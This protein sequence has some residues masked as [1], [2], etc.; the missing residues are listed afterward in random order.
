MILKDVL[1]KIETL[2]GADIVSLKHMAKYVWF[3]GPNGAPTVFAHGE[4]W[5]MAPEKTVM[6]LGMFQGDND[7]RVYTLAV[8]DSK[9][10]PTCYTLDKRSPTMVCESMSLDTFIAEMA[11]EWSVL[12]AEMSTAEKERESIV[13]FLQKM[14]G[15]A[16][17]VGLI[18]EG[19]HLEEEDEE[20]EPVL[21]GQTSSTL[22]NAPPP[23]APS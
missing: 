17:L 6:I 21:P 5:P 3:A 23:G 7:V 14:N 22:P 12:D 15:D 11:D 18:E 19:A 10:P 8:G 13:S 4:D 20:D 1:E 9:H 2:S 16:V